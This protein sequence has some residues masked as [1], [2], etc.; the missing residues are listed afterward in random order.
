ML[1]MLI[2]CH[3]SAIALDYVPLNLESQTQNMN[4]CQS[5]ICIILFVAPHMLLHRSVSV[6]FSFPFMILLY[7]ISCFCTVND[8]ETD[9]I[10]PA[11]AAVAEMNQI[12]ITAF[13]FQSQ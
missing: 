13:Y 7:I 10:P 5:C 8:D 3:F 9:A 11:P 4:V 2:V 1:F 6:C 12:L